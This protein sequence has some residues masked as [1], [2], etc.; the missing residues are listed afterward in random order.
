MFKSHNVKIRYPALQKT[1]KKNGPTRV[2]EVYS[3]K[4][5]IDLFC[6]LIFIL[7]TLIETVVLTHAQL[8]E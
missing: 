6:L 2:N 8:R 5:A 7:L 3:L 4:M 1:K